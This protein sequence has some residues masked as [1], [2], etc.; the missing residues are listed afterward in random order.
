M[1]R[2]GKAVFA[3]LVLAATTAHAS[4]IAPEEVEIVDFKIERSLTGQSGD[5]VAGRET[6][7]DRRLGNCLA[8]HANSDMADEPFHGEVGP[9]LSAVGDRWGEAELRAIVVNSKAVFGE[10]TIMP[11][12]YRLG[13]F[14][15]VREQF[16][17][18]TILTAEEVEDVVAYLLTLKE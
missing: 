16:E 4:V 12:F 17:G 10:Q 11:S 5:P 7:L 9:D 2:S 18:K 8:C 13:P 3:A 14:Y 6:Y 15:R 1:L